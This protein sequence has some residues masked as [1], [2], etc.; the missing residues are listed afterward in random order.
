[1]AKNVLGTNLKPCCQNPMTGFYRDGFCHTSSEDLGMHSICV[2]L[3]DT[4]L[5]FSRQMGNDL[6]TPIPEYQFEGLK[7][8]QK[9][10]LCLNRWLEAYKHNAAPF[11]DLEA[12]HVS[13]L[14]HIDLE[15]L[16]KFSATKS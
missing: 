13:V 10:C 11:L 6:S 1:M 7:A 3:T 9:W 4:F 16:K 12:T 2:H 15:V 14:E 5:K 8:G